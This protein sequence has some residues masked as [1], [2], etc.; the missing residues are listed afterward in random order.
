MGQRFQ[1]ETQNQT[2]TRSGNATFGETFKAPKLFQT[3]TVT[4]IQNNSFRSRM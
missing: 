1:E 2:E 3:Q 4:M